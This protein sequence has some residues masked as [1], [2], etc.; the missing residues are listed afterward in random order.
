MFI[1]AMK[2]L[3]LE[4]TELKN[5]LK[6]SKEV[7]RKLKLSLETSERSRIK[8]KRILRQTNVVLDF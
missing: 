8:L 7:Q 4:V 1:Y 6:K 3:M 5:E 2:S